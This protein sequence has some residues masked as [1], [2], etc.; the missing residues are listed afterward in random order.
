MAVTCSLTVTETSVD[1]ANNKST[2]S[3]KL[4]ATT[5]GDSHNNY[6]SGSYYPSGTIT[7][8]GTSYSIG[9]T[10]PYTS[11]VTLYNKS[12]T[13]AHNSD[14]TK[15]VTVKY[16]FNTHIYAGTLTGSKT[17]NLTAI[18]VDKKS[19]PTVS[20]T[21]VNIGSTITINMNPFKS[22]YT[23]KI[24]YKFNGSSTA[25]TTGLSATSGIKTSC[26][27]TPPASLVSSMNS[28][29]TS[30]T[31]VFTVT[32]YKSDGTSLGSNTVSV[33]VK[34]SASSYPP[35]M[36]TSV[37]ASVYSNNTP[38]TDLYVKNYNGVKLSYGATGQNGA[39]IVSYKISGGGI[40]AT[41]TSTSYTISKLTT[42][43]S[44]TFTVTATDSR[45]ATCS[46]TVTI[47]VTTY[48]PP[49]INSVNTVRCDA[50]GNAADEGTYIKANVSAS[51]SHIGSNTS[52][53]IIIKMQ[54][55][56]DGGDYNSGNNLTVTKNSGRATATGIVGGSLGDGSYKVLYTITD[57]YTNSTTYL[58]VLSTTFYVLDF[59]SGGTSMGIG[60]AA[61]DTEH[62]LTIGMDQI[63]FPNANVE[64]DVTKIDFSAD[65]LQITG[66]A[67]TLTV[68]SLALNSSTITS[69]VS[70]LTL[71][72]SLTASI[73]GLTINPTSL[74][75]TNSGA[76]TIK[77][78]G[79]FTMTNSSTT[80][81]TST[82]DITLSSNYV[83]IK[84]GA[85]LAAA[86]WDTGDN[87]SKSFNVGRVSCLRGVDVPNNIAY[88]CRNSANETWTACMF[89]SDTDYCH[90]GHNDLAGTV[91][92]GGTVRLSSTSGTIV[93]SDERIKKDF[94]TL[95]EY[96]NFFLDLK[97]VAYKYLTGTSDRY[98]IGFKAQEV[99]ESL[100][101]NDL[102]TQDFG[103]YVETDA[104]TDFYI[105]R[106][107]YDPFNGDKM[108]AL[109]Y[110]EFIGLAVHMIQKQ[111]NEIQEL[112]SRVAALEGSDK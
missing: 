67:T 44:V 107:G 102:T 88:R 24:S 104:D 58:D 80:K 86:S 68:D 29:S 6:T 75:I 32:T 52:G 105:D 87:I 33:T 18:A 73:E 22:T 92:R 36:T 60:A 3:V 7:I 59:N 112:K 66:K 26:T 50:D 78:T 49:S 48:S 4:T 37:S 91:L 96:E 61:S 111:H 84:D 17:L 65:A 41:T 69:T 27:F 10:L 103:G 56:A 38:F 77:N 81:I 79:A 95:D 108:S 99:K 76:A 53:S 82:G 83:R 89:V 23:H 15:S 90:L 34:T 31:A 30:A 70:S 16:S 93:S 85:T 20:A 74:S 72:N 100:E 2:I 64:T 62:I 57:A 40:S 54:Y 46:G 109:T 94:K 47:S 101:V 28:N 43:G 110:N 63:N 1:T 9:H 42:S 19:V 106:L 21:S 39:S 8:N 25:I 55:A 45:G 51:Y 5:S 35:S 71:S 12:H 11:T 98:H 14:G 13:I 97:P